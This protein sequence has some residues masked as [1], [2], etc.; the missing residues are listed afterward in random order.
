VAEL[1]CLYEGSVA[2]QEIDHLGH[3]NV[4]F[5]AKRA[6]LATRALA[7]EFGFDAAACAEHGVVLSVPDTYT[8]HYREQL[9]GAKLIVMGGVLSAGESRLRLYHELVNAETGERAATFVQGVELCDRDTRT[10]RPFPSGLA[11]SL[12]AV[13]VEWPEH[14]RP[15]S[16]DLDASPGAL[17][18][19]EAQRRGMELR[20]PRSLRE[21]ECDEMGYFE[22][23]HHQ[24]LAW[25]GIPTDGRSQWPLY[26][27]D[28]GRRLGWATMESSSTLLSTSRVG[29]R[30]Q[31]F[32]AEVDIAS[33]T[34]ER[35][36]WVFDLDTGTPICVSSTV[37]LAF[38]IG[39][40]R[41]IVIPDGLRASLDANHH[42]DLA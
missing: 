6:L 7:A 26:D 17:T 34:S 41:S 22:S 9:A 28:A 2:D 1:R 4:R 32:R 12:Q 23:S 39:A 29:T 27:D 16:I 25:S 5:Y 35:R 14:G 13:A 37:N 33:K 21:D 3:M 8:R 30:I 19:A 10:P 40:R 38:D 42:P 11:E 18:L 20:K 36:T 15:R 31:S 24:E